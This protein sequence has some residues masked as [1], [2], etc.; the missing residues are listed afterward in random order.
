MCQQLAIS[1]VFCT[2]VLFATARPD[3]LFLTVEMEEDPHASPHTSP[4]SWLYQGDIMLSQDQESLLD[5][6]TKDN[7]KTTFP[8]RAY[9]AS[10]DEKRIWYDGVIP[11]VIDCSLKNM[12]GL[13]E[14]VRGAMKEWESKTCVR[15]VEREGE[16]DYL[17][18]F[19]GTHCYST[20]GRAKGKRIMSVGNG[21]EYHHVM[22]HELGHVIGFWHE[23]SRPD[24]DEYVRVLWHNIAKGWENAFLKLSWE[25]V[26]T[27]R[28][29]YDFSSIMHYPFDAFSR[30]NKRTL[31][32][33]IP[34]KATPYTKLTDR[35]V[36]KVNL[37][38]KCSS[39][40][41][42]TSHSDQDEPIEVRHRHKRALQDSARAKRVTRAICRDKLYS[43]KLWAK[44]GFC[45]IRKDFMPTECP[46][47]CK[48][49]QDKNERT[50][51]YEYAIRAPKNTLSVVITDT[52]P[53]VHHGKKIRNNE[54]KK[55]RRKAKKRAKME[56]QQIRKHR[57]TY[58][59][60][61]QKSCKYWAS[62]GFCNTRADFMLKHCQKSCNTCEQD[63]LECFD[64]D[65][66]CRSW[67]RWR[68]CSRSNYRQVMEK[69]CRK[70]CGFCKAGSD[71]CR[72]R[73]PD[74]RCF[75]WRDSGYCSSSDNDIRRAMKTMC[76]KTCD[77]CA[78]KDSKNP[79]NKPP[80]VDRFWECHG[81]HK[82]G[83]CQ[84]RPGYMD[85]YCKKSCGN[86]AVGE[87][88]KHDVCL[89]N[90][91]DCEARKA[92][93]YC[94]K[95]KT[96]MQFNCR[97]TCGMCGTRKSL[98]PAMPVCKDR[99]SWCRK[100]ASYGYC[101]TKA[102]YMLKSCKRSCGICEDPSG[103]K[104]TPVGDPSLPC[105]D[106]HKSCVYWASI[107]VCDVRPTYM[108]KHCRLACRVCTPVKKHEGP[109]CDNK[110]PD[111][112]CDHWAKLGKCAS[113][114]SYM[115]EKC[116]KSC[117]ACPPRLHKLIPEKPKG[118][119]CQLSCKRWI[120]RGL[121]NKWRNRCLRSCLAQ[122]CDDKPVRPAGTCSEP[123]GAGWDYKLSDDAFNASSFIKKGKWD[124]GPRNARL[125]KEDD[126]VYKR[127]GGWCAAGKRNQWLQVDLGNVR[128]IT[129]VAI[130]G[131]DKSYE[132]VKSFELGFSV[133]GKKFY[134][135]REKGKLKTFQGNCDHFTPVVNK[136]HQAH[137]A[138]YVRFYPITH[139]N[140]CMR[141]E[142]YGCDKLRGE[143]KR[144][145]PFVIHPRHYYY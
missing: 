62:R 40:G 136:L 36:L 20:V 94:E 9:M 76:S 13:L 123:F 67:A 64:R 71:A 111:E 57:D 5:L 65:P 114:P 32:P 119:L 27:M 133:D 109:P 79:T 59:K 12:P 113:R 128:I 122:G 50:T 143:A 89:D 88:R 129:A 82:L 33:L 56:L 97:K 70:T 45:E 78:H 55:L 28:V 95:R 115:M 134:K 30:N 135:Y 24:R 19:R 37:M 110:D 72:D 8:H 93:G 116:Q 31:L 125:Y 6:P 80:C 34:V 2:L 4:S 52:T 38:Y 92:Q 66:R 35:D 63:K 26:D 107:G 68:Y 48:I 138:R 42:P 43:C 73:E 121:C 98:K 131:R 137:A 69:F 85:E 25:A 139:S 87:E 140:I 91:V 126:S 127:V 10:R 145:Y 86:C 132:H 7:E 75:H 17:T 47:S 41:P 108:Y 112:E 16:D 22:L 99:T 84:T 14:V 124:F 49:C 101:H 141:V 21:C 53:D 3:G 118:I 29:H 44:Q 74:E 11:Y 15:F 77:F 117:N 102:V 100:W 58:C 81:W 60:D 105:E 1:T 51:T 103:S 39:V 106:K 83:Y 90:E 120:E 61:S 104:A 23:Q 142:I 130:Q 46:K 144:D 54:R 18:I 96:Y